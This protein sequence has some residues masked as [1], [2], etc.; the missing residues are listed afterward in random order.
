MLRK[1]LPLV[2]INWA[3][4]TAFAIVAVAKPNYVRAAAVFIPL[5]FLF[6]FF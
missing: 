4:I 1:I 5:L 6:N 3:V 2:L